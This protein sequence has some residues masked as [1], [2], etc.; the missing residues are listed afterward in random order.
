MKTVTVNASKKYNVLI[1]KGLLD[2]AGTKIR[3]VSKAGKAV[4][5]SDDNVYPIYGEKLVKVLKEE[6]FEVI[7]FVIPHGEKSKN[8]TEY[9][10]LLNLMCEKK[11]T[12]SDVVIGFGGGVVGDLAGFAAATFLRGMGF[13]QIPTSLLAAVDSSVG[14]KTAVDLDAGKNQVGAFY[15]PLIVV[16]DT[17]LLETLPEEEY[18][19]G[20]AEIIKYAM[21]GNSS[22]FD[23]ICATPVKDIY[24]EVIFDCVSMKR[25][26]VERDEYDKG[27]RM[28]L[29]FGHSIGHAVEALS[30][31][32]IPHGQAVAIGMALI[33]KA[34]VNKGICDG[35]VYDRL[36]EL[37]VSY[38]LMTDTNY[39]AGELEKV[40]MNDKKCRVNTIN[41]IVPRNIG[42]CEITEVTKD[43]LLSWTGKDN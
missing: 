10:K 35:E 31:Y 16:C 12:R 13:V 20:C 4:I 3:Q 9:G 32:E 33:T 43:E 1:G 18:S 22:L 5:V 40:M 39:S 41:L 17:D 36:Y 38:N 23:M 8:L 21:I 26:F 6:G 19:N 34:S 29:N 30:L 14:G 15:Q 27:D 2:E 42:H 25:D 24:E 28:M 11:V 37:I 7:E